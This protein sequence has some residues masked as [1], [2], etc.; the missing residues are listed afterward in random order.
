MQRIGVTGAQ[1]SLVKEEYPRLRIREYPASPTEA[2]GRGLAQ[3]GSYR[4]T[5]TG[6]AWELS[7]H[8]EQSS[9]GAI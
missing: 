5:V 2:H 7:K 9:L 8:C 1:A 6:A 4:S 3:P